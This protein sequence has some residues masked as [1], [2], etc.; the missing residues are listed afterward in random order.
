M[1]SFQANKL[2]QISFIGQI[3]NVSTQATNITYK[4]D[5][6]TS[7]I[8]VKQW[9]DSDAADSAAPAYNEDQYVRV[10]GRLKAFN[11]KRHVGAHVIRA[12]DDYNEIS[13]H[14][15]EA[16]YVHLFFTRG[17]PTGAAGGAGGGDGGGMF[18]DQG[19]TNASGMGAMAKQL[20]PMT[21]MARK[22]LNLLQTTPQNNEGLHVNNIAQQ[23]S[24]SSNDVF[25]AGDELLGMGLI[26]T[27]VD[28][29]TWAVL[30]QY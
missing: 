12:V 20:P 22:V 25:K 17:P 15:L 30:E 16:T 24:V 6:G 1:P 27:T 9:I 3:R 13:M 4:L 26:Y 8:E 21:P 29:E 19:A 14:L 11:S 5:D 28:D 10:W 2:V 18:V 23:L 7:L